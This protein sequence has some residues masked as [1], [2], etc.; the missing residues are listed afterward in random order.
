VPLPHGQSLDCLS[1]LDL[2]CS[3]MRVEISVEATDVTLYAQRVGPPAGGILL[4]AFCVAT[5]RGKNGP[6]LQYRAQIIQI[7][8]LTD[9]FC[10]GRIL[11]VARRVSE[12]FSYYKRCIL[13]RKAAKLRTELCNT[14]ASLRVT[15]WH[16][17]FVLLEFTLHTQTD[18]Q[19]RFCS[20]T[21]N[22]LYYCTVHFDNIKILFT[23]E[24]TLY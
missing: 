6:L 20:A 9:I 2:I 1:L 21:Q 5:L 11:W 19:Q 16:L 12:H 14:L 22:Y 23:N 15:F 4:L 13:L 8:V 3:K 7:S 18:R 24:C 10:Q 17:N